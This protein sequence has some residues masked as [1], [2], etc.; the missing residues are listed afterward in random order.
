MPELADRPL[1]LCFQSVAEIRLWAVLRGWGAARQAVVDALL[2]QI[3]VLPYD[4]LMAEQWARV[5]AQRRRA[6]RPIDCG[7]AW[8]AAAALRHSTTLVTH[9]GRDYAHITGLNVVTHA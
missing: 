5:T 6:G 4:A 7:D 9:N 3:I 2:R 8:I 1:A